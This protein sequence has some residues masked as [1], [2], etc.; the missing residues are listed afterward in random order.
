MEKKELCCHRKA[1]GI[2]HLAIWWVGGAAALIPRPAGLNLISPDAF[3]FLTSSCDIGRA[4]ALPARSLL[5][6]HRVLHLL[7]VGDEGLNSI[8]E[9]LRYLCT[10]WR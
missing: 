8:E 10:E 3:L 5:F 7:I 6:I 4:L 2:K 1:A 9:N